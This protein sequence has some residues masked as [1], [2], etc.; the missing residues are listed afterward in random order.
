MQQYGNATVSGN[1]TVNGNTIVNNTDVLRDK[2]DELVSANISVGEIMVCRS[3]KDTSDIILETLSDAE[4]DALS[5]VNYSDEVVSSA[6]SKYVLMTYNYA[7]GTLNAYYN[8]IKGSNVDGTCSEVA[9][10]SLVEYYN[11]KKYCKILDDTTGDRVIWQEEFVKFVDIGYDLGIYDG[12]GTTT[13]KIYKLFKPYY[14]EYN[15]AQ[16]NRDVLFIINAIESYNNQAKPVIANL[17][18]PNLEM[19][20]LL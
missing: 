10:T 3:N 5:R 4:K 17:V 15:K 16:G 8:R 20:I 11:R 6:K 19:V 1:A 12:T 14:I 18:A 7:Q 2:D 13:A 9:A